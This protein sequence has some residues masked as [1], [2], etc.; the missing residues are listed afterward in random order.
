MAEITAYRPDHFGGVER[1]WRS[2]FPGDPARNQAEHAIPQKVAMEDDLFWVAES[3]S[4]AVIGSIMAGWD[5]H[6]GWLYAVAV[7]PSQQRSGVGRDLVRHALA[8]LRK[9]GCGKVNLQIRAGNEAVTAFYRELG[10]EI[11]QRTSMGREI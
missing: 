3:P 7:D 1:L 9:R 8:E 2:V 4:G 10:F 6:R 11:E 5:G